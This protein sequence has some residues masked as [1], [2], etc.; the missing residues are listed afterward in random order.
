VA[1]A[2]VRG[3]RSFGFLVAV[4]VALGA[5]WFFVERK[6][7]TG[8]DAEKKDKAFAVEA[9]KVEEFT[10]KPESGEQTT[11]RKVGTDWQI[12]QPAAKADAAEV[13]SIT[14]SLASL[15]IQRVI[16]E[17][18]ADVSAYSLTPP[19][20]E[21]AFKAAGKDHKVVLGRKT[22]AGSDLYARIDDQP[23]VVLVP[24]Y[25]EA[26]FNRK[27]FDLRDKA[28]LTVNRDE[29]GSL[30]VTTPT[31]SM[32]LEKAG[33]EWKLAQPIAA[34]AD[35]SAVEALVSRLTTL[36]MKSVVEPA[37]TDFAQ[38]GLDKPAATGTIGSGSAQATL[39]L[40]KASGEGTIYARDQSK[41]QVVTVESALLDELKKAPG[42]YRQKD[43]FDARAFNATRIDLV[44]AGVTTTIEKSKS[45]NKDGQEQEVW[46]LVAPA[47]K[48]LDQ[49]K[50]DNLIA[51]VTQTRASSF[52]DAP[53]KEALDKPELVVTIA[54][55]DGKRQEKVSFVR[56]GGDVFGVRDGEPGAAKLDVP[57]LEA[58]TKALEEIK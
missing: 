37:A 30:T 28:V 4:L 51:A 25:V 26:T 49:T 16:D 23:R 20:I 18:P 40:G 38:Y 9:D 22:P 41:P 19:R 2:L 27:T 34:R 7:P 45:K 52:V 29:I 47:A 14:S 36:Q 35:F 46:K 32:R 43:L 21:V 12:V 5:Y 31:T 58:M 56:T 48:D 24:S 44:R 17:K 8:A 3:L 1:E 13:S 55:N 54:S 6:M 33:G 15:E 11:V 57:A 39:A 42:E 50:A 53:A 10:V